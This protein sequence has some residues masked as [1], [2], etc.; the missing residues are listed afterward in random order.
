MT[1]KRQFDRLQSGTAPVPNTSLQSYCS[2]LFLDIETLLLAAEILF[3]SV[4]IKSNFKRIKYI[5]VYIYILTTKHAYY[6]FSHIDQANA[7]TQNQINVMSYKT[8]LKRMHNCTWLT[9]L[10]KEEKSK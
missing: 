9:G 2:S 7:E 3:L 5:T 8:A 10:G 1:W 4:L 6:G